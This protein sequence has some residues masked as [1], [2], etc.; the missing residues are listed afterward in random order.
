MSRKS[1]KPPRKNPFLDNDKDSL[2]DELNSIQDLLGEGK[3][4]NDR[5][6]PADL[7]D[8][9]PV[10]QP[11]SEDDGEEGDEGDGHTQIPLLQPDDASAGGSDAN[12]RLRKALTERE[13]PFLAQ[14]KKAAAE[15]QKKTDIPSLTRDNPFLESKTTEPEQTTPA[16]EPAT[17]QPGGLDEQTMRAMVDEVLAAWLPKI[18]RELRDRLMEYLR[19]SGR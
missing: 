19:D 2:L 8:E 7:E 18:E 14:A 5:V 6:H 4:S 1:G 17:D 10:L 15:A 16:P 13:N 9:L 3:D 11:E 12:Q